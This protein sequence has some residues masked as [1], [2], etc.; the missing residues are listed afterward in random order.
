MK[1]SS[2]SSLFLATLALSS[3]STLAAPAD[4]VGME[5]NALATSSSFRSLALAGRADE[6]VVDIGAPSYRGHTNSAW[7]GAPTCR[8]ASSQ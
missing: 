8:P 4:P 7:D 6:V 2:S 5:H 3:S 1:L